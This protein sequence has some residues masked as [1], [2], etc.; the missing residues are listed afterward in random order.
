MRGGFCLKVSRLVIYSSRFENAGAEQGTKI[1]RRMR[2]SKKI[3]AM[4]IFVSLFC[5]IP[6][7]GSAELLVTPEDYWQYSVLSFDLYD[8]WDSVNYGTVNW[9]ELSWNSGQAA[10]SSSQSPVAAPKH[11]T[12]VANTDLALQKTI[13]ISGSVSNVTLNAAAD[14]GFVIFVNGIQVAKENEGGSAHIWEYTYSL[15]PS[16]FHSGENVIQAFAEDHGVICYFDMQ[17]SADVASVPTP[18]PCSVL[19]FATGLFGLVGFRKRI[20]LQQYK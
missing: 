8:N 19:L 17:L 9:G 16:Y 12:W 11:T 1:D 3:R 2:M 5:L 10:F 4:L 7:Y 15:S 6:L 13:N 20:G 14:N 18:E